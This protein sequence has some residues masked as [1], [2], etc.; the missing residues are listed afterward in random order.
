MAA[1]HFLKAFEDGGAG[2]P[3][4]LAEAAQNSFQAQNWTAAT[5]A[6]IRYAEHP[7]TPVAAKQKAWQSAGYAR[8][9]AGD[10][11]PAAEAF[12]KALEAGDR[13][14]Q[15]HRNLAFALYELKEFQPS[16]NEFIVSLREQKDPRALA[17][18]ARCYQQLKKPGLAIY[19]FDQALQMSQTAAES[20][21]KGEDKLAVLKDV[22]YLDKLVKEYGSA[23][24]ALNEILRTGEDVS[25]R[26]QM[27]RDLRLAGQVDA[28]EQSLAP[29][30]SDGLS[31]TERVAWLDEYGAVMTARGKTD[32]ADLAFREAN[33]IAPAAWRL[34]AG[35]EPAE[36]KEHE[37]SAGRLQSR[38]RKRPE[39]YP[40]YKS[41]GVW[42]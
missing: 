17:G 39:Q 34:S 35:H 26:V 8:M 14:A 31:G 21:L 20:P 40:L 2:H 24:G 36:Q 1:G 15:A 5:E 22:V 37:C 13:S 23:A 11:R 16:V 7:A 9:S 28:A 41:A 10:I 32:A 19:Y 12:R 6:W 3:E 18:V 38:A 29:I 42:L 25:R 27:A 30:H 4:L 33:R